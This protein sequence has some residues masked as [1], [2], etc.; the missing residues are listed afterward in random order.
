MPALRKFTW[1]NQPTRKAGYGLHPLHCYSDGS[2]VRLTETSRKTFSGV[3]V[4]L[5][6]GAAWC[7]FRRGAQR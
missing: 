4:N 1:E 2:H 6:V 7:Y 3:L 5:P